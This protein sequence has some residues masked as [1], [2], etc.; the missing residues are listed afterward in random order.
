MVRRTK[1]RAW[2]A[3]GCIKGPSAGGK[4]EIPVRASSGARRWRRGGSNAV[5]VVPIASE[6]IPLTGTAET[7]VRFS[8]E[9]EYV[10][11]GVR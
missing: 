6:G 7:S 2:A 1:F 10:R 4:S 8:A 9:G 5:Y 11:E 3:F